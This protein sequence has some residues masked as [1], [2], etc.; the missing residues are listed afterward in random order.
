VVHY[1]EEFTIVMSSKKRKK[2]N[3]ERL[4][5]SLGE[6]QRKELESIATTNHTS[7]AFVI[8]YALNHFITEHKDKQL[9]LNLPS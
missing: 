7:L 6:G 9:R 1:G 2:A 8:R 3:Q 4:T 5:I